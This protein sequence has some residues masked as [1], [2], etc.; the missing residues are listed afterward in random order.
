M[1]EQRE[2]LLEIIRILDY[3][4]NKAPQDHGSGEWVENMR[5]GRELLDQF[6]GMLDA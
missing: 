4:V 3:L 5:S 2:T 6:K 1:N